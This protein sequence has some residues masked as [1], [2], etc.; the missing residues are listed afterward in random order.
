MKTDTGYQEL[1]DDFHKFLDE[2]GID[3]QPFPEDHPQAG[4]YRWYVTEYMWKA[5]MRGWLKQMEMCN[6]ELRKLQTNL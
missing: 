4:E 5:Y 1:R 2:M 3:D 6:D